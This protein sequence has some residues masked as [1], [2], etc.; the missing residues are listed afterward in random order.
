MATIAIL[1]TM[2][3]KG[4]EHAFVADRI[5]QRGHQVLVIDVGALGEPR[6]KPDITRREVAAAAGVT[7]MRWWPN[8]TGA[9]QSPPCLKARRLCCR[10]SRRKKKSK[11]SF[12]GRRRRHGDGTAA[13]RALPIG[14]PKVMVSTLAS[15]I[16]RNTSA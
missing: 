12:V 2:D 15:A 8:A 4:E 5:K 6:L 1:G 13:M 10:G 14:F 9:R 11:A 16:P 7:S 3:T